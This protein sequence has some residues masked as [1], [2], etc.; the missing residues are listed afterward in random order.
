MWKGPEE[1]NGDILEGMYA[2]GCEP[3][4]QARLTEGQ[5]EDL[6]QRAKS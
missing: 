4:N 1:D 2:S 6:R 3:L 5:A